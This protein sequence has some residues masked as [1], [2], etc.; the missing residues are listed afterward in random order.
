[1]DWLYD[2]D[3][4]FTALA[5]AGVVGVLFALFFFADPLNVG[6][7]ASPLGSRL[8]GWFGGVVVGY[9]VADRMID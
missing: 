5:V 3:F 6:M 7:D 4:N 1:M 9:F 8:I 2:L